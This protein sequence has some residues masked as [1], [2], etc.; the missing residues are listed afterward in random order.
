M[1]KTRTPPE[2]CQPGGGSPWLSQ[3]LQEEKKGFVTHM[4]YARI[5]PDNPSGPQ[6]L[7]LTHAAAFLGINRVTLAKAIDDGEVPCLRIRRQVLIPVS[8]L[9][10]RYVGDKAP[11]AG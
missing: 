7:N 4:V 8:A 3:P 6:F 1:V 9:A 10:A 5:L 11:N 2:F